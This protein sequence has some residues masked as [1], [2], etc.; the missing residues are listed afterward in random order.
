MLPHNAQDMIKI[1]SNTE[2]HTAI[3]KQIIN[4]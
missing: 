4:V 2:F 3:E 1:L